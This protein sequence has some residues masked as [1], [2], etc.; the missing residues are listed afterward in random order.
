M[1]VA[2]VLAALAG[3]SACGGTGAAALVSRAR[4]AERYVAD[5]APYN[6][7]ER[8]V[9]RDYGDTAAMTVAQVAPLRRAARVTA[10]R[11][12]TQRWPAP[13]RSDVGRLAADLT[14]MDDALVHGLDRRTLV[15]FGQV[16]H[17]AAADAR[18]VRQ[19]LWLPAPER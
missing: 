4:A 16:S 10:A 3:V 12:R 19:D 18:A 17:R 11:L 1:R 15:P 8:A 2:A 14:A 9:A 13:A 5:V 6:R 7:A